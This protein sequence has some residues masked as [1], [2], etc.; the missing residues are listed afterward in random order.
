MSQTPLPPQ[1]YGPTLCQGEREREY[2]E[3]N[4]RRRSGP[5]DHSSVSALELTLSRSSG[6]NQLF[7][8]VRF[9]GL[10]PL[11]GGGQ[12]AVLF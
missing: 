10:Q 3:E 7:F 2:T 11:G 8:G 9:I 12:E 5:E 1:L 4:P 6:H